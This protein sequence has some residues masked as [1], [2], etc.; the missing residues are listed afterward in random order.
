MLKTYS[1]V[2]NISSLV[3]GKAPTL[4]LGQLDGSVSCTEPDTTQ[5]CQTNP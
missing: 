5:T 2:G 4:L 1:S 3:F